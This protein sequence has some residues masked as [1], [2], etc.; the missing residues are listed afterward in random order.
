AM[1]T[2]AASPWIKT[3]LRRDPGG[4]I[5]IFRRYFCSKS[6]S[7][8]RGLLDGGMVVSPNLEVVSSIRIVIAKIE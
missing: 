5:R 7:G 6:S 2:K 3:L 8:E 1:G 4:D